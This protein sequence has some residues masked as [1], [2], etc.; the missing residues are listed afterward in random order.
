[1]ALK[2][3]LFAGDS[4]LE[5]CLVDHSAHVTP[6]AT[7]DHVG[8]I[9]VALVDLDGATISDVELAA[10][11]YGPTTAAAVLAYK[12]KRNIVNTSYQATADDIVGKMTIASLDRE[13]HE[14][15]ERAPALPKLVC[16]RPVGSP[17]PPSPDR[18][19]GNASPDVV[20]TPV[21]RGL[22]ARG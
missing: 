1:M 22:L 14:K 16:S 2:S 11:H 15:Q 18:L 13:M 7:G 17:L 10:K 6:G 21:Q 12:R 8:R 20:L 4:R 19:A 9:Q 3:N 5:A